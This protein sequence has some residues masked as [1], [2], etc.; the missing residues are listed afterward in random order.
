MRIALFITCYNDTLFPQTGVAVT[1]V[2]E[3]LGHSVESPLSQT[4]CGQM[5]NN[6]GYQ[7]EAVPLVRR[8]V[9]TFRS[10]EVVCVPSASCVA[11]MREH[12]EKIA[13]R[14]SVAFLGSGTSAKGVRVV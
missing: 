6:T 8:F 5:H 3:R 12:Y 7:R 10:S 13:E 9:D 11:M 4:C 14:E 1:R 2:L